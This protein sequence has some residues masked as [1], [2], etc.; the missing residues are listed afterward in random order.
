MNSQTTKGCTNPALM[1]MYAKL[2][3]FV[4]SFK[5]DPNDKRRKGN[6]IQILHQAQHIFGYLPEEVQRHVAK[7]L[8]LHHS[9]VSGVISF[10]NFFTTVPKG[11][12]R[13][14]VCMGTA[15]F[16]KGADK[17]L[18]EFEKELNIKAGQVTKDMEFSIDLVRC[19]GACGL[20]PVITIGEKVYGRITKDDVKNIL[21]DYK[22]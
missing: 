16:V 4:D 19:I 5:V 21:S 8:H 22:K 12:Y 2:D 14:N 10:Y 11:K 20:A 9:E 7:K 1:E 17:I 13:V 6:L 15:C 3:S 18:E